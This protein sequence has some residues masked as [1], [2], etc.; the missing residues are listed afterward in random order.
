M[1]STSVE[2]LSKD[3][4]RGK[5]KVAWTAQTEPF[6]SSLPFLLCPPHPCIPGQGEEVGS[7]LQQHG[8][9]ALHGAGSAHPPLPKNNPPSVCR[10][11]YFSK[12]AAL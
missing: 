6:L 3:C 9:I 11:A 2:L 8:N 10:E 7:I 1:W 5:K 12:E 4:R